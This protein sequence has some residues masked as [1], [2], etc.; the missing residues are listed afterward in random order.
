M[1]TRRGFVGAGA[2]AAAMARVPVLAAS[3]A[4]V[5]VVYDS[6]LAGSRAFAAFAANAIDVAVQHPANWRALRRP[7]P[8]G[9][10]AGLTRWSDYVVARGFAEEQRRRVVS[11]RLDRGLVAWEME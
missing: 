5:L 11:E 3:A 2:A 8:P 4:P 9:R 10:I 1:L 6:R 7:L